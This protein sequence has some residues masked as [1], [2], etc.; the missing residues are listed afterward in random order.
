LTVLHLNAEDFDPR[1]LAP[2]LKHRFFLEVGIEAG[3]SK[4][5][6]PVLIANGVTAGQ[7]LVAF[8]GIHGDEFEGIQAVHETFERLN[9]AEMSGRFIVVPIAHLAA[10]HSSHRSSPIDSLNLARTFPGKP[11]G[12]ATER[13]AHYLSEKIIVHADFFIDLHSGGTAY[14]MPAMIG[15]DAADSESGRMSREAA[16]HVGMPVMWGHTKLGP[17][18]S[19]G[20]AAQR[21]IPWLYTES[22]GGCR[23]LAD[24]LVQYK[25]ALENL[26]RFLKI[27]PGALSAS[28]PEVHLLGDGDLDD[29]MFAETAGFF[30]AG[31]NLLDRVE[32]HQVVGLIRDVFGATLAEVRA[33]AKGVV[34]MLRANPVVSPG[35]S[36]CLLAQQTDI[37]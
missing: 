22:A 5:G 13:I 23:V 9:P 16:R 3:E 36:V 2:G 4:V 32:Q 20:E 1:H 31:V 6:F 24:A 26:L 11:D 18:R 14:L 8:A 35:D 37:P 7:T 15:Y 30:V 19:L 17:G 33:P 29:A 27:L 34:A 25:N 10:Y 28:A 21:N 12:T